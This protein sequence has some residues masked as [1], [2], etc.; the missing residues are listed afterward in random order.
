LRVRAKAPSSLRFAGAVHDANGIVGR[1][2]IARGVMAVF[3]P[4]QRQMRRNLLRAPGAD[5]WFNLRL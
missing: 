3:R 2:G 4:E 1:G 5:F